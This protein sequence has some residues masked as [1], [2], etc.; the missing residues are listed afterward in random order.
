MTAAPHKRMQ[1][2]AS[3]LNVKKQLEATANRFWTSVTMNDKTIDD[4]IVEEKKMEAPGV[5]V[6]PCGSGGKKQSNQQNPLQLILTTMF[7][8][9]TTGGNYDTDSVDGAEPVPSLLEHASHSRVVLTKT[10]TTSRSRS[11]GDTSTIPEV[12]PSPIHEQRSAS[13]VKSA[14]QESSKNLFKNDRDKAEEAIQRLRLQHQL[15]HSER[16]VNES[17][18]GS[19]LKEDITVHSKNPSLLSN[20]PSLLSK[21]PSLLSG[22]PSTLGSTL[23]NNRTVSSVNHGTI[24]SSMHIRAGTVSSSMHNRAGTVASSMHNRTVASS[25][26]QEPVQAKQQQQS[27]K[28]SLQ[29]FISPRTNKKNVKT[30]SSKNATGK[31]PVRTRQDHSFFPASKPKDGP[32]KS[33]RG[34]PRK[35]KLRRNKGVPKVVRPVSPLKTRN[36][37]RQKQILN[38]TNGEGK[39]FTDFVE[40]K[41]SE[42]RDADESWDIENDGV[43]DITQVTVDRMVRAISQHVKV[44]PEEAENLNRIHSDVT[45]P[46][47]TPGTLLRDDNDLVEPQFF[48]M[49]GGDVAGFKISPPRGRGRPKGMSPPRFARNIGSMDNSFFTGTTQSTQTNDFA[50]AWRIDEQKFWDKEVE[51]EASK[52]LVK[53]DNNN[54][55]KSPSRMVISKTRRGG[56]TS[57][58]TSTTTATTSFSSPKS[59]NS[60]FVH[61]HDDFAGQDFGL[62][63]EDKLLLQNAVETA[64]I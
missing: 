20:P 53:F 10:I 50:N 39:F 11:R 7:G 6:G 23:S 22:N 42:N 5:S 40:G 38:S 36:T 17:L 24:T 31:A 13:A 43:S 1:P 41:E 25:T 18:N 37:H 46:A 16:M 8:S 26:I 61:T 15:D 49:P 21:N 14:I 28:S 60:R 63:N 54:V 59:R 45:D 44:F 30:S 29:K 64:E 51:K 56:A 33:R 27:R 47:P 55:F 32:A 62:T 3:P 9:C 58:Y 34:D 35:N 4:G 2:P 57:T 48:P 12:T 19:E 52:N